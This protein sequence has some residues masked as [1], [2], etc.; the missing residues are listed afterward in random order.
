MSASV[1]VYLQ[2]CSWPKK[3]KNNAEIYYM[4]VSVFRYSLPHGYLHIYLSN[5]NVDIQQILI[6]HWEIG[7]NKNSLK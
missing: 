7:M 4:I 5:V 1:I 6:T 3:N 2:R